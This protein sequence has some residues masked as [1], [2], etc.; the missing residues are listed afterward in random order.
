MS[1]LRG[2]NGELLLGMCLQECT[3]IWVKNE[4][5]ISSLSCVLIARLVIFL[6]HTSET[7][8]RHSM[9]KLLL[10]SSCCFLFLLC[11]CVCV[12][13]LKLLQWMCIELAVCLVLVFTQSSIL[14]WITENS[15]VGLDCKM[16]PLTKTPTAYVCLSDRS[17]IRHKQKEIQ[18]SPQQCHQVKERRFVWRYSCVKNTSGSFPWSKS[19]IIWSQQRA[20][21]VTQ[22]ATWG[23]RQGNTSWQAITRKRRER[24]MYLQIQFAE[25]AKY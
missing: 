6:S 15:V 2:I 17:H 24:N 11:V 12:C 22:R 25:I 16:L 9:W 19:P 1:R 18:I 13:V 23:Q 20:A 21:E 10:V 8:A 14:R 5:R 3:H 7:N 4:V